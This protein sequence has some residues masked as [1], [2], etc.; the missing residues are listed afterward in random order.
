MVT[1]RRGEEP[2]KSVKMRKCEKGIEIDWKGNLTG[3]PA[4]DAKISGV[5][6]GEEIEKCEEKQKKKTLLEREVK[7]LPIPHHHNHHNP[8][9]KRVLVAFPSSFLPIRDPELPSPFLPL[10]SSFKRG[11]QTSTHHTTWPQT[12]QLRPRSTTIWERKASG[13]KIRSWHLRTARLTPR[14]HL[15]LI[16][17]FV[18][19]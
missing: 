18:Y 16:R 3:A 13:R 5:W 7:K 1:R 12:I 2:A 4:A 11:G 6:K 14:W 10:P 9:V 8:I 17:A 19:P 15:Y